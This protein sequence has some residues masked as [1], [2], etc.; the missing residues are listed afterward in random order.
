VPAGVALIDPVTAYGTTGAYIWRYTII[1]Y[2]D[3]TYA[4]PMQFESGNGLLTLASS[5][6]SATLSRNVVTLG[7]FGST[8]S[9]SQGPQTPM[10]IGKVANTL[11]FYGPTAADLRDGMTFFATSGITQAD[12]L[13]IAPL[14]GSL[15]GGTNITLTGSTSAGTAIYQRVCIEVGGL[16][17]TI[18]MRC[19]TG[20]T[21]GTN[22]QMLGSFY[23][24][25]PSTIIGTRIAQL[26]PSATGS[27][28]NAAN[29]QLTAP[30]PFFCSPGTYILGM[31]PI[32]GSGASGTATL[33]A[34]TSIAPSPFGTSISGTG[35]G[36]TGSIGYITS[37]SQGS[38][39]LS[40][41]PPSAASA[42][43]ATEVS[44]SIK[45]T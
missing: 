4:V 8:P 9:Y 7:V 44:L 27:I 33:R 1:E 32:A 14:Q 24:T 34:A 22:S 25:N 36:N 12:F 35:T 38:L 30:T 10:N 39:V 37:A 31:L 13:G 19:V 28:G 43:T 6:G 3:T 15:A 18:T 5:V 42:S 45:P 17:G 26:N 23:D 29:V 41:L 11:V 40:G 16:I 2:T 20:F 21:A